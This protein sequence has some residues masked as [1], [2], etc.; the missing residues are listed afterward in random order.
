[1]ISNVNPSA[2][3]V[4]QLPSGKW[5]AT[6]TVGS[7]RGAKKRTKTLPTKKAALTWVTTKQASGVP[8][9]DAAEMTVAQ[10]FDTYIES[11]VLAPNT[12]EVFVTAKGHTIAHGIGGVKLAALKPSQVDTF[13]AWMVRQGLAASTVNIYAA[14]LCAVLRFAAADGAMTFMPKASTVR[15]TKVKEPAITAT[16]VK[17]LYEASSETFAP[18]IIFGAY[19]GMRASEAAAITVADIDFIASTITV[20]KAVD[21][22]GVFVQT[23]TSRSMRTIPVPP[24]VLAQVGEACKGRAATE[25]VATNNDGRILSTDSSAKTFAKVADAAGVDVTYHA[26]RKFF[27]TTLLSSGVNP[28][29]VAKYLGDTVQ[30]MLATYAL[31]QTTDADEARDA[32]AGAF[33]ATVAA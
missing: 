20:S 2:G 29:A 6:I 28:V 13:T 7:G 26:L 14:K 9:G 15:V 22:K 10:T 5:L 12:V 23:K 17:A 3:A 30:T 8:D 18:A 25:P 32:I 4:R 1:M 27:A 11:K 24:E 19:A 33:R 31:E 21:D 16:D